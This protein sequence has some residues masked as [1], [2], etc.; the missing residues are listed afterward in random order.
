MND[1][2]DLREDGSF[3]AGIETRHTVNTDDEELKLINQSIHKFINQSFYLF[4]FN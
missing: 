2:T 3:A 1:E 4:M